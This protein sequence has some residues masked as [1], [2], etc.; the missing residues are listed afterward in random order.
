MTPRNLKLL[1]I[2]TLGLLCLY[3]T[4]GP[5]VATSA[6]P[7][8]IRNATANAIGNFQEVPGGY[9]NLFWN[10]PYFSGIS[11]NDIIPATNLLLFTAVTCEGPQGTSCSSHMSFSF[12]VSGSGTMWLSLIGSSDDGGANGNLSFNGI[13]EPWYVDS[14]SLVMTPFSLQ[15]GWG[16]YSGDFSITSLAAGHSLDLPIAFETGSGVPE[17]ASALLLIGGIAV[18]E[19]LRRKSRR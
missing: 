19:F 8:Q 18:V 16:H 5:A 12:D 17:P 9:T 1:Y 10:E 14:G 6:G 13:T 3:V 7:P 4:T 15:V 2:L 11:N